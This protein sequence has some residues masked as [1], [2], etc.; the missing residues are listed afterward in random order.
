M[1]G[2]DV[3]Y[4]DINCGISKNLKVAGFHMWEIFVMSASTPTSMFWIE[5]VF[6]LCQPPNNKLANLNNF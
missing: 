4:N 5:K 6:H 2:F 3:D 1:I